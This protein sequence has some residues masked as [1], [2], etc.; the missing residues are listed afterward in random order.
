MPRR[1]AIG[2]AGPGVLFGATLLA[3]SGASAAQGLNGVHP[4]T[5]VLWPRDA[6]C[7]TVVDRTV[8]PVLHLDYDIPY[9]D[10]EDPADVFPD[11]VADSRTHQFFALCRDYHPWERL[12]NYVSLA[13]TEAA[14]ANG[15]LEPGDLEIEDVLD[16]S[17]VWN[18][19]HTRIVADA[20]R[21]PI[22][23]EYADAG[24]DWDTTGV[25]PGAYAIEGFTHE[26]AFNFYWHRPGVVKV[27]DGD[28][29]AAGPAAA[30]V[31]P[32]A[33]HYAGCPM[34]IEGCVNAPAGTTATLSYAGTLDQER[35]GWAPTWVE[36]VVDAPISGDTFELEF[37]PPPEVAG[38]PVL[39]RVDFVDPQ[40][41]STTAYVHAEVFVLAGNDPTCGAGGTTTFEPDGGSTAGDDD[42]PGPT[43]ATSDADGGSTAAVTEDTSLAGPTSDCACRTGG[44]SPGAVTLWALCVLATRRR[45]VR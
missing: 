42:A 34:P 32:A 26:P 33:V 20:D 25:A 36:A 31:D 18:G 40:G 19:C 17:E 35:P 10:P 7:M 6:A 8:D 45:R 3:A 41:L 2:V 24:V 16:T 13:D 12:P 14:I 23:F 1:L 30:I 37:V 21:R 39:V 15:L 28:A 11:E 5:P 9:E 27:I 29:D 38:A 43:D 44:G 4:R 22:F